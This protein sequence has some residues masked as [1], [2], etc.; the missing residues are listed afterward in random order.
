MRV[1]VCDFPCEVDKARTVLLVSCSSQTGGW[2]SG[3]R[4]AGLM[5]LLAET[6]LCDRDVGCVG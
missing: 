1:C 6:L 2:S 4:T 3:A 5:S